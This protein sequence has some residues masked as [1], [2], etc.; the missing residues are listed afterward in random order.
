M[1]EIKKEPFEEPRTGGRVV[2]GVFDQ[3]DQADGAVRELLEQG[4]PA[5]RVGVVRRAAGSPPGLDA[6]QTAADEGMAAGAAVGGVLGGGAGLALSLSALAVP[7]I[8]PI[9]AAGPLIAALA[10]AAV[11]GAAGGLLGSFLGMGIPESEAREYE[12]AVRQG[13]I[14]VSV[15]TDSADEAERVQAQLTARGARAVNSYDPSL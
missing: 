14:F 13:G 2:V 12:S 3:P 11:G 7:G 9:L 10:G 1:Q 15:A 4:Y 5:D 6:D 8:G